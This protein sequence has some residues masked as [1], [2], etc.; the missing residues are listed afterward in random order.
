MGGGGGPSNGESLL[1]VGSS[2][3]THL[4]FVEACLRSSA[5]LPPGPLCSKRPGRV[6]CPSAV[7]RLP[8]AI[9]YPSPSVEAAADD[10]PLPSVPGP[11]RCRWMACAHRRI[12]RRCFG[13]GRG[14]R[15]GAGKVAEAEGFGMRL[16]G[17]P[18]V[19]FD[20]SGP[21]RLHRLC[22]MLALQL[23]EGAHTGRWTLNKR[24]GGV[25]LSSRL[26]SSSFAP[27]GTLTECSQQPLPVSLQ[28][29]SITRP[30]RCQ[31]PPEHD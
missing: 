20:D 26:F 12:N 14:G 25:P 5:P 31:L 16:R 8:T 21:S 4:C 17:C 23:D 3:I 24:G 27:S 22:G 18:V 7:H 30:N 1:P 19:R 6:L 29:P 11:T 28:P 15:R 13:R 10:R 2:G 9:W